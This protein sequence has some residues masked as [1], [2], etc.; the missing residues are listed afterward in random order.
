MGEKQT[1]KSH[2]YRDDFSLPC[3]DVILSEFLSPGMNVLDIGCA[4][5]G[6]IA[7]FLKKHGVNVYS[8]ELN[9]DAIAEFSRRPDSQG[10]ELITADMTKLPF[11]DQFFDMVMIA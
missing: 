7:R 1:A 9:H 6:R 10:I 5:S 4:A 3:E 8:I 2:I 11:Q